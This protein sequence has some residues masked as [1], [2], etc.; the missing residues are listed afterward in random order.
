MNWFKGEWYK[1]YNGGLARFDGS[2]GEMPMP[3]FYHPDLARPP[4]MGRVM[5]RWNGEMMSSPEE[6]ERCSPW[7]VMQDDEGVAARHAAAVIPMG[8]NM[9]PARTE[10]ARR[11][12][13]ALE[14]KNQI[15]VRAAEFKMQVAELRFVPERRGK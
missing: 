8:A 15:L 9:K 2:I 6:R 11:E 5:H 4:W 13:K 1:R 10:V 14:A 7:D 12:A 3:C